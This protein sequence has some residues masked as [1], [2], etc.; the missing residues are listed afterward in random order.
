MVNC[1]LVDHSE[2]SRSP[3]DARGRLDD[4]KVRPDLRDIRSSGSVDLIH[5]D[6]PDPGK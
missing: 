3:L 1:D 2:S 4:D 6:H 5:P